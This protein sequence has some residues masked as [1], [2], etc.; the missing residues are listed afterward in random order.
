MKQDHKELQ[1][2]IE[3]C[4]RLVDHLTDEEMRRALE[5]LASEYEARLTKKPGSFMLASRSDGS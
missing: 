1:K 3:R 2:T 4:R 5:E